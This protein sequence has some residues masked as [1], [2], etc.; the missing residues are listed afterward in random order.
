M[1][2]SVNQTA[3]TDEWH[4]QRVSSAVA[5]AVAWSAA[6]DHSA[7][8]CAMDSS[9]PIFLRSVSA[10]AVAIAVEIE[11]ELAMRRTGSSLLTMDEREYITA[12]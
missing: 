9:A 10:A 11:M 12:P 5:L 2:M 4:H 6:A 3:V 1:P 8:I 7:F